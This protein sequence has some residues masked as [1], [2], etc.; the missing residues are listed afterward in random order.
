MRLPCTLETTN[1]VNHWNSSSNSEILLNLPSYLGHL[2][3]IQVNEVSKVL[4]AY[5]EVFADTPGYC[6]IMHHDVEL[7]PGTTPIH[8]APH[9]LPHQ[10]KEQV[11]KEVDYLLDHG[12]AVPSNSPWASPCL[13]VPKEDGQVRLC[14]DY[15]RVNTVTVTDAY[16]IPRIDDLIDAVGQSKFISKIDLLKGYHQIP[17]TEKAQL[18][19]AFI[20]PFGRYHYLVMLF[21]MRNS[22]AT[23]QRIMNYLLQDLDGVQVYLDDIII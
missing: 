1:L 20:T 8:Q 9:R 13:L 12:L 19:S 21:G 2:D 22:P 15:R 17:L 3:L 18:I 11:K 6:T 7:I 4:S 14:T 5:P 16:P 10:K 23:F